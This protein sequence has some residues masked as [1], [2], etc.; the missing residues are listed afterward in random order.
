M[1][2]MTLFLRETAR[3]RNGDPKA[4]NH[5]R[6]G[7]DFPPPGS[8]KRPEHDAALTRS[9]AVT[10][11][12]ARIACSIPPWKYS[13][14]GCSS[15]PLARPA[16]QILSSVRQILSCKSALLDAKTGVLDA[17]R[18]VLNATGAVLEAEGVVL[19]PTGAVLEP[20]G[21]VLAAT[22][23]I[24]EAKGAVLEAKGVFLGPTNAFL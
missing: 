24:L 14:A 9:S 21:H 3:C 15:G 6:V 13:G 7:R 23:T 17:K 20:T 5:D 2:D 16:R 8:A 22:D 4:R 19:E 18:A 1:L 12:G 11:C 10:Q